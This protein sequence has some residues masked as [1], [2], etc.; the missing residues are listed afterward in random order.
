MLKLKLLLASFLI[1]FSVSSWGQQTTAAPVQKQTTAAPVQNNS[2][3]TLPQFVNIAGFTCS[4]YKSSFDLFSLS[5][6]LSIYSTYKVEQSCDATYFYNLTLASM[7]AQSNTSTKSLLTLKGSAYGYT[8]DV[9]LSPV[10]NKFFY[11]GKLRF[12]KTGEVRFSIID[13]I[14]NNAWSNA[15]KIANVVNSSYTA[16][17]LHSQMHYIWNIGSLAHELIAPNGDRYIMYTFTNQIATDLSRDNL[18]GLGSRL[19]L[20]AGWS[21]QNSL[22]S[23][24]VTVYPTPLTNFQSMVVFDD[25]NNFYVKHKQ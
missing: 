23:Q 12:S 10:T 13:A 6:V 21:Y 15:L 1:S 5:F 8:M 20:P 7:D 19:N 16:F 17:T 11:V 18:I 14:K 4:F 22:L 9:N 25:F 3:T 2:P 24:T